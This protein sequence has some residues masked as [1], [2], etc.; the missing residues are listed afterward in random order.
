[1]LLCVFV[2]CKNSKM[3]S[4]IEEWTDGNND[5][6]STQGGKE[7]TNGNATEGNNGDNGNSSESGNNGSDSSDIGIGDYL[8]FG[9][10][11]QTLKAID[12]TVS[13]TTDSRGYYLGSD[14]CYYAK[15]AAKPYQAGYKLSDGTT[16]VKSNSVYY[17]KVEPIKWRIVSK[18]G[19]EAVLICESAIDAKRFDDDLNNYEASEIRAWLNGEFVKLAFSESEIS[20]VLDSE[21]DNSASTTASQTNSYACN[22]TRDKVLLVSYQD[23][24]GYSS[25]ALRAKRASDYAVACGA[26]VSTADGYYGNSMWLLRSP[27]NIANHF[28]CYCDQ[29]G[30]LNDGGTALSSTFFGITPSIKIKL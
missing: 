23:T 13:G 20:S 30:D 21:V 9:E 24:L 29:Y 18:N 27:S 5:T 2:S 1:M 15:V 11:P 10:Y 25:N 19:S 7:T 8:Y 6:S 12:V 14:N 4:V 28:V 26:W 16:T 22:N 17:F 3:P